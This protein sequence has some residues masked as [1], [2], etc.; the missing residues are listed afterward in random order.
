M[1]KFELIEPTSSKRFRKE[2]WHMLGSFT[3]ILLEIVSASCFILIDHL[4]TVGLELVA[5][6]AQIDYEQTGEHIVNI[7]V[8][9]A[10]FP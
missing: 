10:I 7:T 2:Y 9:K 8:R 5:Q 3:K 6:H 1:E 4:L